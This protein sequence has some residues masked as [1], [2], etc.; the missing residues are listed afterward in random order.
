MITVTKQQQELAAYLH[1]V[2]DFCVR[3]GQSTGRMFVGNTRDQ[4]FRYVS[5]CHLTGRL[6]VRME[7]NRPSAIIICWP[8][9]AERIEA[10]AA[11]GKPQFEW[12]KVHKGD[13]VFCAEVI[14]DRD[15]LRELYNGMIQA[16]PNLM[17]MRIFTMRHGKLA[18]LPQTTIERFMR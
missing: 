10:K 3:R 9:F 4:I 13:S 2:T 8:E 15:S 12:T 18:Q 16:F 6:Q 5:F 1:A 14:A 17:T 7:H 11:E